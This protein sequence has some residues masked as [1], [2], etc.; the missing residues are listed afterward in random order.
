MIYCI[1]KVKR[2]MIIIDKIE[3]RGMYFV[4]QELPN[5]IFYEGYCNDEKVFQIKNNFEK[6]LQEWCKVIKK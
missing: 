6:A 4:G 5:V 1:K 3:E 2:K